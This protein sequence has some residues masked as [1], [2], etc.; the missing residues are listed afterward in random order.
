MTTLNILI[1]SFQIY[2]KIRFQV[3]TTVSATA[4]FSWGFFTAIKIF[5]KENRRCKKLYPHNSR[6][7]SISKWF[8]WREWVYY[9]E[10][11]GSEA[12]YSFVLCVWEGGFTWD[13]DLSCLWVIHS[14][15]TWFKTV[16][17][18][19][20]FSFFFDASFSLFKA[21]SIKKDMNFPFPRRNVHQNNSRAEWLCG[22]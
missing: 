21:W 3:H 13:W 5:G 16:K 19:F 18:T 2:F 20:F 6:Y 12:S 11:Y 22:E 1:L 17:I 7:V 4:E 15:D 9:V 14:Q 10:T 8:G